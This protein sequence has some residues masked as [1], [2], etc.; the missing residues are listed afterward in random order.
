MGLSPRNMQD[1][2][3]VFRGPVIAKALFNRSSGSE[4]IHTYLVELVPPQSPLELLRAVATS[5]NWGPARPTT[6][7]AR[8]WPLVGAQAMHM[9]SE[10]CWAV[11]HLAVLLLW[12][13]RLTIITSPRGLDPALTSRCTHHRTSNFPQTAP[14]VGSQFSD[15]AHGWVGS[16]PSGS[17][18]MNFVES[19]L[20][21]WAL[22][23]QRF[24]RELGMIE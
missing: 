13:S 10:A 24:V 7:F 20:K 9:M 11:N 15:W 19:E 3:F 6:R 2:G 23:G 16:R 18:T 12:Y 4:D 8:V 14:I 21:S 1:L 5:F 17:I 22:T